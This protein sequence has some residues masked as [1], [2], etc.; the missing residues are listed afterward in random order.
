MTRG[1]PEHRWRAEQVRSTVF[2]PGSGSATQGVLSYVRGVAFL[3]VGSGTEDRLLYRSTNEGVS[4]SQVLA[5]SELLHNANFKFRNT[6]T[7]LPSGDLLFHT[8]NNR[9][10]SSDGGDRWS[11]DTGTNPPGNSYGVWATEEAIWAANDSSGMQLFRSTDDA[12]SWTT[13]VNHK[14]GSRVAASMYAVFQAEE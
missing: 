10:R 1:V 6:V 5:P 3:S 12:E 2:N 11:D 14:S 9:Y 7:M 8:K 4:W 13:I